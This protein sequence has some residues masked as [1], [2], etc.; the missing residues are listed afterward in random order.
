[1]CCV[2]LHAAAPAVLRPGLRRRLAQEGHWPLRCA[3]GCQVLAATSPPFAG[4]PPPRPPLPTCKPARRSDRR[5]R[6]AAEQSRTAG[7]A[8]AAA[9][10]ESDPTR[11][12]IRPF[13][14]I[15]CPT[16]TPISVL[17]PCCPC[18]SAPP[19]RPLPLCVPRCELHG[20]DAL[21]RGHRRCIRRRLIAAACPLALRCCRCLFSVAVRIAV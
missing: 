8:T 2:C 19:R 21:C 16:L 6:T 12:R 18:R 7:G 14:T 10:R 20:R 15:A 1:M 17:T 9:G 4:R 5:S 11:L 3:V 13:S